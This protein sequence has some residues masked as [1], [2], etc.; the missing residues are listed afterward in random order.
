MGRVTFDIS[1]SLDGFITAA[2][3]T[4]EEPLGHGGERLH[5]WAMSSDE[6]GRELL[7]AAVERL[8]AAICG[9]RTYDDSL[10]WWGADGPT[11]DA[12]RPLFV[13]THSEPDSIIEDGVYEF[14]TD[15][16]EAALERAQDVAGD[17]DVTIMG[18]ADTGRQYLA[19]G[20]VDEVSIHLV[21]VL[22]GGGTRIFDST[23]EHLELEPIEVLQTPAA[24]H[25]RYRVVGR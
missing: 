19:A 9:R 4:A 17:A 16:I 11:G 14:V 7:E 22:F 1:M 25:Q 20:L 6:R 18:G 12:R 8:G 3:Q 10:P 2:D 15:G 24:I 5:E 13:L 21:P 23:G